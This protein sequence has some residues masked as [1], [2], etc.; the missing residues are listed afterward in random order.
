MHTITVREFSPQ[1]LNACVA[2]YMDAFSRAPWF[3][4]WESP[5]EAEAF[6]CRHIANNYFLGYV[7]YVGDALA[8]ASFGFQKPWPAGMEYYIDE[9]FVDPALQGQGVGS[10]LLDGIRQ[11]LK[12]RDIHAIIL[13]TDPDAPA[14]R[15]YLKNGFSEEEAC[16]FLSTSF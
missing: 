8:G 16:V 6:L 9:F 12:R 10:A 13:T 5:G 1:D 7:A 3:D 14:H 11:D 15:F 4:T 2:L